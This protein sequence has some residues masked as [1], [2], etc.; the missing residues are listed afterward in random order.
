MQPASSPRQCIA[1]QLGKPQQSEREWGEGLGRKGD[2]TLL[3]EGVGE[4]GIHESGRTLED[5]HRLN[6][7][8]SH[9]YSYQNK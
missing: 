7:L 9:Y 6:Q 5:G 8:K 3:G 2:V 4:V 1:P